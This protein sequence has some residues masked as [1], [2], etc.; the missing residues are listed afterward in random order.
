MSVAVVI[1]Y[2]VLEATTRQ[3]L[4]EAV[5]EAISQGW[6]PLGSLTISGGIFY[7]AVVGS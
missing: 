6:Q 4:E 2:K 5:R 1:A 7:Q 3:A